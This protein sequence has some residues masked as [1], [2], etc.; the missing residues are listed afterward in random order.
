MTPRPMGKGKFW[1]G[2]HRTIEQQMTGLDQ[3]WR[4]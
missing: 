4:A 1:F 2:G 3:L